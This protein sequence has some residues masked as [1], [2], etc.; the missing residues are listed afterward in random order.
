MANDTYNKEWCDERHK[1]IIGK[2]ITNK[3]LTDKEF[4]V[5]WDKINNLDNRLWFVIVLLFMNLGG[6]IISIL[7][8]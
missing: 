2:V 8:R 6:V 1:E 5:I 4:I 7:S 3:G